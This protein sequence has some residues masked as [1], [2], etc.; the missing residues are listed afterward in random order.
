MKNT[1]FFK[2]DIVRFYIISY[3]SLLLQTGQ[4]Q[5]LTDHQGQLF[6]LVKQA[7]HTHTHMARAMIGRFTKARTAQPA[8]QGAVAKGVSK[9]KSLETSCKLQK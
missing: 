9:I 6:D 4:N 3:C 5:E 1:C 7:T 2:V 8:G